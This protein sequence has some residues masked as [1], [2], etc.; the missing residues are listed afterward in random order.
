MKIDTAYTKNL[1]GHLC[2]HR[3]GAIASVLD[4]MIYDMQEQPAEN[5]YTCPH[6]RFQ[7]KVYTGKDGKCRWVAPYGGDTTDS[8][9]DAKEA[10]IQ[11]RD[12]LYAVALGK[13]GPVSQG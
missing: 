7:Q 9:A 10:L 6:L 4:R 2:R 13:E 12:E 1:L 11:A 5:D 3:A 8:Y